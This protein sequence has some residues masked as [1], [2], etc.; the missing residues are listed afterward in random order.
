MSPGETLR[1][2]SFWIAILIAFSVGAVGGFLTP[3]DIWYE[4]L[5]KP[6]FQPPDWLFGP[7]WTTIFL[8]SAY[9]A[10]RLWVANTAGGSERKQLIVLFSFNAVLNIGWS[11]LFFYLQRPDLALYE[12]FILW[13]SV[14]LIMFLAC[15][16][17]PFTRWLMLPY[18]L[19]VSFAIVLNTAIVRLNAP[20]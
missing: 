10:H 18:L 19:W 12:A 1:S 11:F 16:R 15:A 13:I 3:L 4:T 8:L 2:R 17:V 20:F 14:A 6:F 7:A 9:V 5:E